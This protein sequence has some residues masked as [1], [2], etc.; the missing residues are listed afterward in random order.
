MHD[1][2]QLQ[3]TQRAISR[4]NQYSIRHVPKRAYQRYRSSSRRPYHMPSAVKKKKYSSR[5]LESGPEISPIRY[6]KRKFAH[7]ELVGELR[8]IKPQPLMEKLDEV[9]MLKLGCWDLESSSSCI[10]THQTW[11]Q[12]YSSTIC[13][14]KHPFGGIS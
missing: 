10:S 13:K 6:K 5:S 9:K 12:G 7:N 11:N 14:V 4:N 3:R 2:K 8:R 1:L